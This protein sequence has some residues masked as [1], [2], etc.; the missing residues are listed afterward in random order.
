MPFEI[1]ITYALVICYPLRRLLSV[2]PFRRDFSLHDHVKGR[3]GYDK[4]AAGIIFAG[5]GLA[6]AGMSAKLPLGDSIRLGPGV[7]PLVL[8]GLLT[9]M[10]FVH[11]VLG[12]HSGEYKPIGKLISK[13][14]IL[15]PLSA[16]AFG[17][18]IDRFG[19]VPAVV[20]TTVLA[21]SADRKP[22]VIDIVI[23]TVLLTGFSVGIFYYSL[24]MPF[25]LFRG[26]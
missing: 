1:R 10:G 2:W 14:V 17:L 15:I 3:I 12:V 19:L 9:V 11:I 7:F 23:M 4:L 25:S 16:V 22:R 20:V 13:P 18:T 26:F 6:A 5:A 8:G 21:C 24:R